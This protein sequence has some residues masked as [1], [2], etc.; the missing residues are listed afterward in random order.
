MA[1]LPLWSRFDSSGQEQIPWRASCHRALDAA[2]VGELDPANPLLG[3][4]VRHVD[5]GISPRVESTADDRHIGG[6]RNGLM[7]RAVHRRMYGQLGGRG[8]YAGDILYVF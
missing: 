5:P 6:R 3:L 4:V 1:G 2:Q 8:G 7:D